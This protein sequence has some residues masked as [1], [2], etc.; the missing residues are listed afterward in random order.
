VDKSSR[1]REHILKLKKGR[2]ATD[3]RQHFFAERVINTW[4]YLDSTVVEAGTLNTPKS[5]LQKLHNNDDSF[6][7]SH[8]FS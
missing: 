8:T 6:F 1:T 5:K 7:G 4:N 3:L 2:V